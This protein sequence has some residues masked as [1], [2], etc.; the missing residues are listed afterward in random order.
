MAGPKWDDTE[1]LSSVSADAPAWDDT[2][3]LPSEWESAGRG[4]AQG[5]SM[6]LVDEGV[7]AAKGFWD[8]LQAVFST[9]NTR[10]KAEYDEFGRVSNADKLNEASSYERH[11][12]EYRAADSV[13]K[14][15]NPNAYLAGEIG[16]S[17]ASSF[18]PG[19]G[20]LNAA[21][22]AKAATVIGK[23][24]LQGG[25]AGFGLSEADNVTGLVRDAGIGA[26]IGAGMGATGLGVGK[27]F[28]KAADYAVSKVPG[29]T[30]L[31]NKGFAKNAK[32]WSGVDEDA[33]LRAIERPSQ[34]GAAEA[35]GFAYKLA[36]DAQE[37]VAKQGDELGS[38][39]G[40]ARDDIVRNRGDELVEG[41]EDLVLDAG[42]FMVRNKPSKKGGFSGVTEK[43]MNLLKTLQGGLENA[44]AEDLLK[45]REFIDNK[46][47]HLYG[48][49]GA[50]SPFERQLM[51]MRG[52]ADTLLDGFDAQLNSANTK[53]SN[54]L[55]DKS[56][57]GMSNER[58]M[59]SVADNLYSGANKTAKRQAAERLLPA[60]MIE[61]FKDTAA[62]KAF[63]AAK[64]PGGDNYFRRITLP[65]LSFGASEIVTSPDLQKR[66]LKGVGL[67]Q[68]G[69]DN[70]LKTNP[71]VFGKFANTLKSAAQRGAHS[72]SATD[73]VL[74]QTN[75]EYRQLK[76]SLDGGDDGEQ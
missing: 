58:T 56:V 60:Q 32:F 74:Q 21:K 41:T 63:E 15:A 33:A 64:R 52:Q 37:A 7:G 22:G 19:L 69:I 65:Q 75:P 29:A 67:A 71:E 48:R 51:Q 1:E 36:Q 39:V 28:G 6:G 30:K 26:T 46:V 66:I 68:Q 3:D 31:V 50:A 53:Y 34:L 43:E 5:L 20:A 23:A 2:E 11:R 38:A 73:Y 27:G 12:D 49:E 16:G 47:S 45:F 62:N 59:E 57:L 35:E 25:V 61:G 54:Y 13:A 44:N 72:L 10:P 40:F 76:K 4:T 14:E 24:A 8:D 70:L 55:N 18:V 17:V 9:E 42:S